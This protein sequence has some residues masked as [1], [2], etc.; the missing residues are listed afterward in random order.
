MSTAIEVQGGGGGEGR[1]GGQGIKQSLNV[2]QRLHPLKDNLKVIEQAGINCRT[3][4]CCV[5]G[6]VLRPLQDPLMFLLQPFGFSLFR[7]C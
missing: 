5:L 6:K 4:S 2:P 3:M 7:R 1:E